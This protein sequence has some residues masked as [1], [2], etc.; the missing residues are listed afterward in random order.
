MSAIVSL[1]AD[2]YP[3]LPDYEELPHPQP[4]QQ[5]TADEAGKEV[6]STMVDLYE[7]SGGG[8]AAL[9]VHGVLSEDFMVHFT[10]LA[11]Y[12]MRHEKAQHF[13]ASQPAIVAEL[14]RYTAILFTTTGSIYWTLCDFDY[15]LK[16]LGA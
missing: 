5:A 8:S 7:S 6:L 15:C 12:I 9:V 13:C 2:K 11:Y 3:I 1:A 10:I 4:I 14:R 16:Q